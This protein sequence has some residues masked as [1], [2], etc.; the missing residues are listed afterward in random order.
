MKVS[1]RMVLKDRLK[2]LGIF[3]LIVFIPVLVL[4]VVMMSYG[5]SEAVNIIVT[6]VELFVLFFLYLYVCSLIDKKKEKRLKESGKK[7]PFSEE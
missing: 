4:S 3:C 5:V 1:E 2:K 6:V 7:D